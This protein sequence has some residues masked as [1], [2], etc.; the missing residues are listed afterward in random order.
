[1]DGLCNVKALEVKRE[2]GRGLCKR[3]SQLV[4]PDNLRNGQ[5]L[6]R[7]REM[8][9]WCGVGVEGSVRGKAGEEK[10]GNRQGWWAWC[11]GGGYSAYCA[12]FRGGTT[13]GQGRR[14]PK[15]DAGADLGNGNGNK[16]KRE[17]TEKQKKRGG[18][19]IYYCHVRVC[20][21]G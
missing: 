5:L 3:G 12:Y 11:V 6:E 2:T 15:S 9:G 1:M 21:P 4:G 7:E 8:C 10:G 19:G 17:G 14:E 20:S 16:K 18:K 13:R